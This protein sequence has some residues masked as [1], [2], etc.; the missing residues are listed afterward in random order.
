MCENWVGGACVRSASVPAAPLLIATEP[1]ESEK[2]GRKIYPLGNGVS[3]DR[4]AASTSFVALLLIG[5]R[6]VS[7]TSSTGFSKRSL[8]ISAK[9]CKAIAPVTESGNVT[10][11]VEP[12]TGDERIY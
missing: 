4:I 1:P 3:R 5:N 2:S 8:S 10:E 6:S 7:S 9:S 11:N 12:R